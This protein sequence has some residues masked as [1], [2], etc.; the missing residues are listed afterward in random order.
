MTLQ[1]K[2]KTSLKTIMKVFGATAILIGS[3]NM[4]LGQ[5]NLDANALNTAAAGILGFK[6]GLL[7]GSVLT[8]AVNQQQRMEQRS[9]R[10]QQRRGSRPFSRRRFGPRLIESLGSGNVV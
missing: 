5:L 10:R 3:L 9:F 8:N 7:A 6:G 1:R 4:V 2:E